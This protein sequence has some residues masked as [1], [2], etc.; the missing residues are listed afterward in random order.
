MNGPPPLRLADVLRLSPPEPPPSEPI[1]FCRASYCAGLADHPGRHSGL[2]YELLD[3]HG[4]P[5]RPGAV[6]TCHPEETTEG[7]ER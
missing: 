6:C 2:H 7:S 5:N 4:V 1:W 3:E